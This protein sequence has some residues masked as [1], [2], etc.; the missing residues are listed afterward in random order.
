M[1]RQKPTTRSYFMFSTGF[2]TRNLKDSLIFLL[3]CGYIIRR[4]TFQLRPPFSLVYGAEAMVLV[5]VM[6]PSV[7]LPL[8]SRLSNRHGRIFDV[9]ALEGRR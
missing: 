9:D 5:E 7:R 6:V 8:M 4:N 2:S 1:V 3:P